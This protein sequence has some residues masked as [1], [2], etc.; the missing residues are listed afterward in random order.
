LDEATATWERALEL[1][2]RNFHTIEQLAFA[3]QEQLAIP[4]RRRYE[5]RSPSCGRSGN[6]HFSG[7]VAVDGGR[8]Q[9]FE[10]VLTA[11]SLKIRASRPTW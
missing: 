2:P 3:Y 6:P 10:R 1:D 7:S 9:T 4:R 5:R 11:S 8:H